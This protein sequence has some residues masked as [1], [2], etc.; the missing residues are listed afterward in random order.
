[1]LG[2]CSASRIPHWKEAEGCPPRPQPSELQVWTLGALPPCPQRM[3]RVAVNQRTRRRD[4]RP[5]C[6][7]LGNLTE[8]MC[9]DMHAEVCAHTHV[10]GHPSAHLSVQGAHARTWVC[11]QVMHTDAHACAH[12]LCREGLGS[13]QSR[14]L[15]VRRLSRL[16]EAGTGENITLPEKRELSGC[17]GWL[18]R[19]WVTSAP[20][21]ACQHPSWPASP[22]PGLSD[23]SWPTS[24]PLGLSTPILAC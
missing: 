5:F 24:P 18:G 8:H 17:P 12:T 19:E 22:P 4:S 21:L 15:P 20:L 16:L 11:R 3:G 2:F 10:R 9:A 7:P 6:P 14:K 13:G 23:P 1:M